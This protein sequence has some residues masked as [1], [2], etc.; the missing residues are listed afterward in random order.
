MWLP[1]SKCRTTGVHCIHVNQDIEF[2]VIP[3]IEQLVLDMEA[4]KRNTRCRKNVE[5]R[6]CKTL[7]QFLATI[8]STACSLF[9]KRQFLRCLYLLAFHPGFHSL[10]I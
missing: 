7:V 5:A 1:A 3:H 4:L 9:R 8:M 6:I 2:E 10:L